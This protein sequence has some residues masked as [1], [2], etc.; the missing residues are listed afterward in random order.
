MVIF[1]DDAK[2]QSSWDPLL[3]LTSWNFLTLRF[4]LFTIAIYG[5]LFDPLTNQKYISCVLWGCECVCDFQF[6]I[7]FSPRSLASI[8][9]LVSF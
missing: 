5:H 2:I 8:S 4:K 9:D 6:T 1:L 7:L 3:A